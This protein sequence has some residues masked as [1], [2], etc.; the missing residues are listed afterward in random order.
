MIGYSERGSQALS[1]GSYG[2]KLASEFDIFLFICTSIS[3]WEG[4]GADY[5]ETNRK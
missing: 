3:L 2:T 4:L 5:F 1:N